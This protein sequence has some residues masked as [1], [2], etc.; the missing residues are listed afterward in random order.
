MVA[1]SLLGRIGQMD[2][3]AFAERRMFDLRLRVE[4]Y[5]NIRT[6]ASETP[7]LPTSYQP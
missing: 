3:N 6:K 5:H 1:S 4:P 7:D 2:G